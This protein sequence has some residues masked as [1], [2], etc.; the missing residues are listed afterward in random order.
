[1]LSLLP[2]QHFKPS[3][4]DVQARD[5]LLDHL[6]EILN[7]RFGSGFDVEYVGLG[8]YATDIRQAPFEVAI[9][10]CIRF[11]LLAKIHLRIAPQDIQSELGIVGRDYTS[12]LPDI[13]SPLYVT[14]S[15]HYTR[16]RM[17]LPGRLREL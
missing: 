7:E 6:I 12:D 11:P 14:S 9:I 5:E 3:E 1:M 16:G 13:Y 15:H 10:V 4:E 8:R 2:L 17:M